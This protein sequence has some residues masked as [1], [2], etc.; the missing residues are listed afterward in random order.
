MSCMRLRKAIPDAPVTVEATMIVEETIA[1]LVYWLELSIPSNSLLPILV[2]E[3]SWRVVV[4]R[5][6]HCVVEVE[7]IIVVSLNLITA[8]LLAISTD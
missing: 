4:F 2:M 6:S 3:G 7:V 8:A 1:P 5:I